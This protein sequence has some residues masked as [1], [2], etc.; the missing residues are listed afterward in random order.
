MLR[1]RYLFPALEIVPNSTFSDPLV[2]A[3]LSMSNSPIKGLPL[4]YKYDFILLAN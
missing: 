4:K 1:I 2:Y 3:G